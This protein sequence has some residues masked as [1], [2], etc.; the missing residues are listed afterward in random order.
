MC[1]AHLAKGIAPC[2]SLSAISSYAAEAADPW[3]FSLVAVHAAFAAS[4]A[5]FGL[6]GQQYK[7]FWREIINPIGLLAE[8]VELTLPMAI[9][10]ITK[11]QAWK[12]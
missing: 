8:L 9:E 10:S 4:T 12:A 5:S 2:C 6:S 11:V 3:D 1:R 7:D